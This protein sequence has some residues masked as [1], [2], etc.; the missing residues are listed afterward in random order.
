MNQWPK[1]VII[2]TPIRI[3]QHTLCSHCCQLIVFSPSLAYKTVS[4]VNG[5]L[6]ILDQVK[7]RLT[8]LEFLSE[9]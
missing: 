5:P 1:H 6:V 2:S 7:V 9:L 4:G 3:S 8:E